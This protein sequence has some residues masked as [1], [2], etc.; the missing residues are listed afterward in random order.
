MKYFTVTIFIAMLFAAC[1]TPEELINEPVEVESG[2]RLPEW[3][4]SNR[5]SSSDSTHFNGYSMATAVDSIDA[6]NLGLESA[7]VNL[8]YEIDK[9]T[10]EVREEL[11]SE[12][13]NR[14]QFIINLRNTV[15]ELSLT[16]SRFEREFGMRDDDVTQV[17]T[18]ASL[19]RSQV[20]DRLSELLSDEVYI[21]ALQAN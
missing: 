2:E 20:I 17:Y 13:H 18:R 8:R 16:D 10:E 12:Q 21:R 4:N 7:I 3:V 5:V 15:Q 14:P 6:I 19:N 11:D 1:S 9:F